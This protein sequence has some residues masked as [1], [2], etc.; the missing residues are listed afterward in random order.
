MCRGMS[1]ISRNE[2]QKRALS[3]GWL[4]HW[5]NSPVAQQKLQGIAADPQDLKGS[6]D[7]LR[8]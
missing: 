7:E 6:G 3:R 1:S 8:G 2:W 4:R 5:G